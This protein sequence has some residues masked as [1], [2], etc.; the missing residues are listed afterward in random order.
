MDIGTKTPVSGASPTT[1]H[2]QLPSST[3]Q[4]AAQ[5]TQPPGIVIRL[6]QANSLA[7]AASAMPAVPDR[8]SFFISRPTAGSPRS[9]LCAAARDGRFE[10]VR[11]M[12]KAGSG[13][14]NTI[15]PNTGMSALTL[16]VQNGH[17]DVVRKLCKGA[18]AE[19]IHREDA[20]GN[21]ALLLAARLGK[22]KVAQCLLEAGARSDHANAHGDTALMLAARHGHADTV[23]L[24]ANTANINLVN[25]DGDTALILAARGGHFEIVQRLLDKHAHAGQRN[26]RGETAV[27]RPAPRSIWQ[28]PR[29]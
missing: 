3:P 15:D 19:D 23:N 25:L 13:N 6:P 1:P 9:R 29:A 8:A 24:L 16:A 28:R 20:Q 27:Y 12:I 21:S 7:P 2:A 11:S 4:Q 26:A 18:S 17:H 5:P 22:C 10:E 14:L